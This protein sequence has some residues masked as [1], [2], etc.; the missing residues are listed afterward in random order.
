M[1]AIWF[2]IACLVLAGIGVWIVVEIDDGNNPLY[3]LGSVLV[4]FGSSI[5]LALPPISMS[6]SWATEQR[7]KKAMLG[8]GIVKYDSTGVAVCDSVWQDVWEGVK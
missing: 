3:G 4:I 8:T 5:A 1:V 2:W 6:T 7:T